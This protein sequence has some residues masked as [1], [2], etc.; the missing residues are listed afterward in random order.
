V[1]I[2]SN[3]TALVAGRC[4]G[5]ALTAYLM[6]EP[7]R[8]DRR[9]GLNAGSRFTEYRRACGV[10]EK[11]GRQSRVDFHSWRRWFTTE[12]RN[13]GHDSFTVDVLTGH[14]ARGIT[15]RVYNSGPSDGMMRAA[16]ESVTLPPIP[17]AV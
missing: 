7:K 16:V 5:K 6:H 2:H 12:C 14:A 11:N 13:A 10:D 17:A 4:A 15:D 1:P 8:T 3:L 9:R